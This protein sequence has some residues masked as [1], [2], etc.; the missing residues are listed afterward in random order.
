[1]IY[2]PTDD[3]IMFWRCETNLRRVEGDDLY[4]DTFLSEWWN[5]FYLKHNNQ[6]TALIRIREIS[7]VL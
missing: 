6:Y 1:M 7:I 3:R 5:V 2:A 4:S